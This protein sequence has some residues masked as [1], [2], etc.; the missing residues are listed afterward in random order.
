MTQPGISAGNRVQ[1]YNKT[2]L[3]VTAE[4]PAD[5]KFFPQKSLPTL[6]PLPSYFISG[7]QL[8]R[9]LGSETED[10]NFAEYILKWLRGE[11]EVE[12]EASLVY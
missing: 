3:G 8:L 7:V 4:Y 2:F 1:L 6:L 10:S 9:C 11:K 5:L 12:K